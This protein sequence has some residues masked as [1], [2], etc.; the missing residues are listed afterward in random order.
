MPDSTS[1]QVSPVES[2]SSPSLH[3]IIE[4]PAVVVFDESVRR[5][6]YER[7]LD[8]VVTVHKP[9]S[10]GEAQ[11][12]V[13]ETTAVAIVRHELSEE[14]RNRIDSLLSRF[15]PQSRLICATS[16]HIQVFNT[17]PAAH[18]HLS[19]PV[20]K[21]RLREAVCQQ[22]RI[23]VYTI[24]LSQ[25]YECTTQLA[26]A[27]LGAEVS[28]SAHER[29]DRTADAL[30]DVVDGLGG[31]LSDDERDEVFDLITR[32]EEEVP[33]TTVNSQS[34]YK[35]EDCLK[36]DSTPKNRAAFRS[37]GAYVWECNSCGAVYERPAAAN[38]RVAK[39]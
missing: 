37:L 32:D 8:D 29:L 4:S 33:L 30:S 15:G 19:E 24:A 9:T 20:G 27:R 18:V 1:R 10:C 3:P 22:A 17:T 21:E 35:P 12:A 26:G 7:W 36:C 16:S 11:T 25:Y 34:K 5:D 13:D 14:M 39:R 23:A 31:K 6:L 38:K 28:E 2:D